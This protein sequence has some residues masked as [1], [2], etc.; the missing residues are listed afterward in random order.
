M[1]ETLGPEMNM[2]SLE[3]RELWTEYEEA[4]TN[5]AKFVKDLDKFEMICQAYEYE[6]G[7]AATPSIIQ[8]Q[9]IAQGM[10]LQSFFD[11]TSKR[12]WWHSQVKDLVTNL[13]ERRQS[14]WTRSTE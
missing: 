1:C 4:Q 2:P 8:P 9:K 13:L 3:I 5:E 14:F 6:Q 10:K 7:T 11:Y 12:E